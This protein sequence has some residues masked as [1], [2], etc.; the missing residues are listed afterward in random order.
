ML[1]KVDE[2]RAVPA[3]STTADIFANVE[4]EFFQMNSQWL[5]VVS[6]AATGLR[7]TASIG[8]ELIVDDQPVPTSNRY[9]IS[10]D[11]DYAN[12]VALQGDKL[13][14]K[15]RNTTGAAV[16]CTTVLKAAA[17]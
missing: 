16:N 5:L 1:T 10:P 14:V 9:P 4:P 2:A 7:M 8:S 13:I 12:G 6:A 15:L 11:D 17:L 3:N